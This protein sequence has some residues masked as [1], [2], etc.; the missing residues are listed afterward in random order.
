MRAA[1]SPVPNREDTAV[2]SA[3]GSWNDS[4]SASGFKLSCTELDKLSLCSTAGTGKE[5]QEL[6]GHTD[7]H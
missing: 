3:T 2:A 4:F 1:E 7:L 6:H 5:E